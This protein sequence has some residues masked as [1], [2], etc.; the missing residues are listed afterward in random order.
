MQFLA[1]ILFLRAEGALI[2]I[3][4]LI[5]FSKFDYFKHLQMAL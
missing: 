5:C 1:K 4:V 3:K 2:E